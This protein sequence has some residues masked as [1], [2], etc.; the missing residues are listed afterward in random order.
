MGLCKCGKTTN[1]GYE[2]CYGCSKKNNSSN[3]Q[4]EEIK[5]LLWKINENL[6]YIRANICQDDELLT[7][8]NESKREKKSWSAD[9][10]ILF[11]Q[12]RRVQNR[13]KEVKNTIYKDKPV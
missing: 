11:L 8:L 1:E 5:I 9:Y 2:E 3:K 12:T 7:K 6:G 13:A 4:L 10:K